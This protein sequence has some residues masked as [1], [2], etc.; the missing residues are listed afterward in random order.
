MEEKEFCGT[1]NITNRKSI[2]IDGVESINGFDAGYVA[3]STKLGKTIIEGQNLKVENMSKE[4]GSIYITGKIDSV[5]FAEQKPH[6]SIAK[7]LFK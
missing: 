5:F 3:L 7:R 2:E 1:V 4:N 6:S